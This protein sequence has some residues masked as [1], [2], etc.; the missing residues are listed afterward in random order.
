MSC[1]LREKSPGQYLK[2]TKKGENDSNH[3]LV[4][5][6]APFVM[7]CHG[8]EKRVN[9]IWRFSLDRSYRKGKVYKLKFCL[10]I[11]TSSL[12]HFQ[13]KAFKSSQNHVRPHIL[14]II[15]K[16]TKL[17]MTSDDNDKDKR[18]YKDKDKDKMTKRPN[19]CHIFENDIT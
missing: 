15:G 16:S 17:A 8:T 19:M 6:Y 5:F 13:Y 10:S 1:L 14:Y 3:F 11:C 4:Q 12:Q 9:S 7:F 2:L 18:K